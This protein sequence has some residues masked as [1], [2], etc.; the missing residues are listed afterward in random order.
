MYEPDDLGPRNSAPIFTS[1]RR[2]RPRRARWPA[3][4]VIGALAAAGGTWYFLDTRDATSAPSPSFD[5]VEP[6]A[7]VE[8]EPAI[9][10][11]MPTDLPSLGASDELLR[12]L[13]PALSAHPRVAEWFATD[14]LIRRFVVS[15]V[16]L[17]Q[18]RSP[19][20]RLEFMAPSGDIGV[21]AA[22]ERLILDPDSYRRYDGIAEAFGSMDAEGVAE[23]YHRLRPLFDQAYR[24]LGLPRRTFDEQL[25]LAFGR[26]LAFEPPEGPVVMVDEGGIYELADPRLEQLSPAAKHLLRMGPDN[27]RLVQA[28]TREI[29]RAMGIDPRVPGR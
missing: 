14:A 1:R 12:R 18:G 8:A 2:R 15:V 5:V 24:E 23:L 21:R 25:A 27:A 29:A 22:G 16:N 26:V 13:A 20:A 10:R 9:A 6:L 17:A 7:A 3:L 11:T 28:K 19:R 4:L